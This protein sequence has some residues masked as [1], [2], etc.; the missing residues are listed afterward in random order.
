MAF[1][2]SK[3]HELLAQYRDQRVTLSEELLTSR[4]SYGDWCHWVNLDTCTIAFDHDPDNL[5]LLGN[6]G[7]SEVGN[8]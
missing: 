5:S 8:E 2:I 7:S 3:L 4:A 6:D 1:R